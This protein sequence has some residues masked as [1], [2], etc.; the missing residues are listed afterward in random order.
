MAV[1]LLLLTVVSGLLPHTL[2]AQS[3]D[4]DSAL[5]SDS[6]SISPDSTL[7]VAD[8]TSVVPDSTRQENRSGLTAVVNYKATDSLVFSMG[9]MAYLYG[10][11][12]V[13]YDDIN[14]SAE[15][16]QLSLDSSLVH[17]NGVKDT[18]SENPNALIG[19]PV[20]K[21]KSGEYETKTISYNFKTAKGYITDVVTEQG[22]GYVTGG[23]TKKMPDNDI[24]LENGRY[25]TCD[26]HE[27]PHFYIKLTKA[28]VRPGKNIVTG[29]AYLVVADVPLPLA[30]PFG[31]FPFT[32]SYSSGFIMP[33]YGSDMNS[34]LYL[35]D[36]GWYF[37]I[38][39]YFDLA[40]KG[41]LYTK[42]TW[43]ISGA[44]K[45]NVRY[46]FSG[47]VSMSY[48]N[49]VSGEKGM[50][51]YS[52][53]K[54]F[55]LRWQHSQDSRF[56]PNL[57]LSASVDFSSTGYDRN[58]IAGYYTNDMTTSNKQSSVN[59]SYKIPNTKWSLS[60]TMSI[61]QNMQD[62]SLNIVLPELSVT[63]SRIYPFKRKAKVG[64]DR[65]YEKITLDYKGRFSNKIKSRQ[66]E[67]MQKSLIKDWNNGAQHSMHTDATFSLLKYINITPSFDFTDRMY[68]S[69]VKQWW[70]EHMENSDGTYGGV[71]S[72]TTYGFYNS[73]D[74]SMA[75]SAQTTLYGMYKPAPFLF[76]NP[77][78]V[79]VRHL[80]KPSISLSYNPDF[81]NHKF[82]TWSSYQKPDSTSAT[83]YKEVEYTYFKGASFS[84]T[85]KKLAGS[86]NFNIDNNIE[87]KVR[88]DKDSTGYKK[89]S[90]IDKLS[91]G[92]S[93]NMAADSMRWSQTSSVNMTIKPNKNTTMNLNGTFDNYEYEISPNGKSLYHVDR[94]RLWHGKL[95]RLMN[96]SY[97]YSFQLNNK[98]VASWFGYGDDSEDGKKGNDD[99]NEDDGFEDYDPNADPT[100]P[101]Y[102]REKQREREEKAKKKFKG[103]GGYDDDGYLI[104]EIPWSMNIAYSM[105][106]TY[107]N[108][109]I[110]FAKK[111]YHRHIVHTATVSGSINP[112]KAWDFGY[113]MT[114]DF[115]AKKVSYLSFTMSRDMHCWNLRASMSPIG[116]FAHFNVCIAVKSSM[117]SDLKYEKSSV[118]RSNKIDWYDD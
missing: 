27:C 7:L 108:Q 106:Y 110:D 59:L 16:I 6:T 12:E 98:K 111:E 84:P 29:P 17:A 90:I 80:F 54:D 96:T 18:A 73:Y 15:R 57:T 53:R 46:K 44:T 62:S 102:Q 52:V 55:K 11:S 38:N 78:L 42:G 23:V 105:H 4:V 99:E 22:D 69:S 93:Y 72:D 20:F 82:G 113:N 9:N 109:D 64:A 10:N 68:T 67:I 81:T 70:D 3:Q 41:D 104:W 89:I 36:G 32:K 48:L 118:S 61:G 40:L 66:D 94:F 83:G 43:G 95:P 74:Y 8:S 1:L 5:N 34:G 101:V 60:S 19:A 47:T 45:Y 85:S 25:T 37:A 63:M 79:A 86:I 56:N 33:T 28:R 30:V 14:L 116:Q 31:F 13:T 21:D 112:T 100:D 92:L 76:K 91:T 50:P 117:L 26:Y 75:V 35:R 58:N 65:W 115:N 87:A 97:S 2:H 39:D 77:K 51:D 71:A 103:K 114:Y 24:F 49:S 88:S 107:N